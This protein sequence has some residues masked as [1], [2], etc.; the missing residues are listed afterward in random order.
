MH[1]L[2]V[3]VVVRDDQLEAALGR[4]RLEPF[5]DLNGERELLG[6]VCE[7]DLQSLAG[8]TLTDLRERG[9]LGFGRRLGRRCRRARIRCGGR[10]R[11]GSRLLVPPA[12][13]GRGQDDHGKSSDK[14]SFPVSDPRRV[15]R[16]L[17]LIA[18]QV[19]QTI[20]ECPANDSGIVIGRVGGCQ[21]PV[22]E[23]ED[24]VGVAG[25]ER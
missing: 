23:A 2:L 3:E 24:A 11:R 8:L 7:P 6:D 19:P 22:L 13:R 14:E 12:A 18:L 16:F 10:G 1:L 5:P 15:H 25:Q 4:H 9:R 21:P 20:P 17:L